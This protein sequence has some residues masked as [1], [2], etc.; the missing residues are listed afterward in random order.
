MTVRG[1][2]VKVTT[3]KS[4]ISQIR[5]PRPGASAGL[6]LNLCYHIYL[7]LPFTA[8]ISSGSSAE[9]VLPLVDTL[10]EAL[11]IAGGKG[12]GGEV[13]LEQILLLEIN[14]ELALE[15]LKQKTSS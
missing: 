12:W 14:E 13:W 1:G 5:E 7:L 2:R 11:L 10:M 8:F 4:C 15:T 6:R 9:L 3:G